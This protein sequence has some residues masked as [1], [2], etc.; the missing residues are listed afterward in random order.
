MWVVSRRWQIFAAPQDCPFN[1][2]NF[3]TVIVNSEDCFLI[4][5]IILYLEW[6]EA[7]KEEEDDCDEHDDDL[8]P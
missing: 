5:I 7:G 8:A 2:S 3:R 6:E 1:L 4:A